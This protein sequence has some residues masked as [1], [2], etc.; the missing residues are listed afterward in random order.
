MLSLLLTL[1]FADTAP[2]ACVPAVQAG[3]SVAEADASFVRLM[4]EAS[5]LIGS[6]LSNPYDISIAIITFG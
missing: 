4:S 3:P 5:V 2:A 6:E 1:A